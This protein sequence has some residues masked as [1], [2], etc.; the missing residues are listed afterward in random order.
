MRTVRSVQLEQR[1][2]RQQ[3][4]QDG[5][6]ARQVDDLPELAASVGGLH[7]LL[8]VGPRSAVHVRDVVQNG[9]KRDVIRLR[10][11]AADEHVQFSFTYAKVKK[12]LTDFGLRR[13]PIPAYTIAVVWT[14][15]VTLKPVSGEVGN[16]FVSAVLL[17]SVSVRCF[18][19]VR[20]LAFDDGASVSCED[21]EDRNQKRVA[22]E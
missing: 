2:G 6:R 16:S 19:S 11:G 21:K 17:S 15:S 3:Q 5:R 9:M 14:I 13:Q 4:A 22:T 8:A 1:C 7:P 18:S 10:E 12:R 20:W